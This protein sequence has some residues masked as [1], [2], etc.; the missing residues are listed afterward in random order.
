MFLFKMI[1]IRSLHIVRSLNSTRDGI[2]RSLTAQFHGNHR[3]FTDNCSTQCCTLSEEETRGWGGAIEFSSP[4]PLLPLPSAKKLTGAS[5]D[6]RF[7]AC[8]CG[9]AVRWPP[10]PPP[11]SLLVNITNSRKLPS[12]M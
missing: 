6:G 8:N 9:L 4:P 3:S 5:H 2:V 7:G 1:A 10:P 11:P 12:I